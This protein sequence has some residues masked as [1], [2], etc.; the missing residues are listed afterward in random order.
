MKPTTRIEKS[1]R[2]GCSCPTCSKNWKDY[3]KL[4]NRSRRRTIKQMTTKQSE[5]ML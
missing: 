1:V 2:F 5:E 3:K 4:A